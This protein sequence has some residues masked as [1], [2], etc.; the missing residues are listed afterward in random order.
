MNLLLINKIKAKEEEIAECEKE[1]KS[2]EYHLKVTL[3]NELDELNDLLYDEGIIDYVE[4]AWA[5]EAEEEW[6][7]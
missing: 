1:I 3:Q 7:G 4:L 6:K 5:Q 2:L